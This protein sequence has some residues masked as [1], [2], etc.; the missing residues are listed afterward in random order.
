MRSSQRGFTLVELLV[1]ITIIGTL[2]SLLLPA[3]QSARESGR[4]VTCQNS[5]K[6][7]GLALISYEQNR[8]RFPGYVNRIGDDP[9]PRAAEKQIRMSWAGMIFPYMEADN[10]YDRWKEGHAAIFDGSAPLTAPSNELLNCP[11]DPPDFEGLPT[12]SYAVNAGMIRDTPSQPGNENIANGMFFNNDCLRVDP[13]CRAIAMSNRYLDSHDGTT[14]TIMV[15]ENVHTLFY[16]Y[17]D[18][19]T[20]KY[21]ESIQPWNQHFGIVWQ[22]TQANST[23]TGINTNL[24]VPV[25]SFS[26]LAPQ[27]GFPSSQHTGYVNVVFAD[28][29]V[30]TMQESVD[31]KV[32]RQLMTTRDEASDNATKG[33]II[34]S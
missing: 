21:V 29:H 28:G 14:Q 17:V 32:Y 18:P 9:D 16:A 2:M 34:G 15:S 20:G 26:D 12:L 23:F 1:V 27:L 22:N 19:V 10:A 5:L 13:N 4:S 25:N 6:N 31:P 11:S 3:V 7:L 33:F 30:D 24:D 8:K